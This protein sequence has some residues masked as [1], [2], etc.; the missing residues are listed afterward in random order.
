MPKEIAPSNASDQSKLLKLKL[1]SYVEGIIEL[2]SQNSMSQTDPVQYWAARRDSQTDIANYALKI[3]S[4][5]A[6]S[7]VIERVFSLAA[8][9]QGGQRRRLGAKNT[10]KELMIKVNRSYL[11]NRLP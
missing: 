4:A 11:M 2:A 9:V 5:P 7:A 3:L 6:S 10:E 1:E 8:I